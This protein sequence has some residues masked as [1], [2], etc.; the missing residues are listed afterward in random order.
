MFEG[1]VWVFTSSWPPFFISY[2]CWI[3]SLSKLHK[4]WL[5]SFSSSAIT[6]D[7]GNSKGVNL[8][9]VCLPK[10]WKHSFPHRVY[11][12]RANCYFLTVLQSVAQSVFNAS[13]GVRDLGLLSWTPLTVFPPQVSC[14]RE[15][16]TIAQLLNSLCVTCHLER[17]FS[18]PSWLQSL[19]KQTYDLQPQLHG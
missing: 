18:L 13:Q 11:S 14:V 2:Q 9:H 19:F 3:N 15:K 12:S 6:T 16:K 17:L 5:P 10:K 8:E 4:I 7:A 1:C